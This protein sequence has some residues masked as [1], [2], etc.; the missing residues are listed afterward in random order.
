MPDFIMAEMLLMWK[1]HYQDNKE[2]YAHTDAMG[3]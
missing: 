1:P 3:K 2:E